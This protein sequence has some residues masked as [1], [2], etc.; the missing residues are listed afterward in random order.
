MNACVYTNSFQI[1]LDVKTIFDHIGQFHTVSH[2]FTP[3]HLVPVL[4]QDFDNEELRLV[5]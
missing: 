2:R 4:L 3:F 5:G 1:D